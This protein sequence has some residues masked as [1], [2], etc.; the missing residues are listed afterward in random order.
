[1]KNRDFTTHVNTHLMT[2]SL[3]FFRYTC[4]GFWIFGGSLLGDI[5]ASQY[6]IHPTPSIG[7]VRFIVHGYWVD[8]GVVVPPA[9]WHCATS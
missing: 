5:G 1:M 7:F 8:T 2:S 9:R 4:G 3:Q 6:L